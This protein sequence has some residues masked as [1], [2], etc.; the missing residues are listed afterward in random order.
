VETK[1]KVTR[2]EAKEIVDMVGKL[3][4]DD[5]KIAKGYLS[6]LVDMQELKEQKEAG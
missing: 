4:E 6:A 1:E 2:E 5:V 3:H